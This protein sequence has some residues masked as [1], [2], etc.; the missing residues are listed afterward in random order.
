MNWFLFVL[1]VLAY[2]GAWVGFVWSVFVLPDKL[3]VYKK[4]P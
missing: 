2:V 3:K 1:L 4:G